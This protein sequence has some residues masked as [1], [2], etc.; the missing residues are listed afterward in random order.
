M[1]RTF[2]VNSV[3]SDFASASA[4]ERAIH[5]DAPATFGEGPQVARDP[6]GDHFFFAGRRDAVRHSAV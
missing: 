5:L 3:R 1:P 6:E 4:R 2:L